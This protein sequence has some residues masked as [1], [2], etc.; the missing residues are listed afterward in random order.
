MLAVQGDFDAHARALQNAG[1]APVLIK[2]ACQL[3]E[4]DALILPGGESTTALK[5]LLE[6][7]LAEAIR[8]LAAGGRPIFGTCAGAILL[9]R[10]VT[11]TGGSTFVQPGEGL[12]PSLA[13]MDIAIRRNG[14]GSQLNSFIARHDFGATWP[15]GPLEMVFIRAPV[16]ER[17]GSGVQ[18]VAE[19][20]GFP[21]LVR[22]ENLL[23]AT[24]HPELTADL[25]IHRYFLGMA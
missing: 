6:E 18:V 3:T 12:Q 7:R 8:E 23:A 9:A 17:M 13:L 19:Y 22:Q 16:I 20:G 25:R 4:V 5:F 10:E 24:F 14:Y 1:A 21:V 15:G 2:N 11:N